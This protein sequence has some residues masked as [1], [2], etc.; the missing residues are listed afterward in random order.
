[1]CKSMLLLLGSP[2]SGYY[3]GKAKINLIISTP[4]G[5]VPYSGSK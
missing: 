2:C 1:M 5:E 3:A 4:I